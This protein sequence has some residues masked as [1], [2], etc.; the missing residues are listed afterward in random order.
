[1]IKNEISRA[2]LESAQLHPRAPKTP[3]PQFVDTWH[4]FLDATETEK[5]LFLSACGPCSHLIGSVPD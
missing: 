1:M 2:K 4:I 5:L 3:A